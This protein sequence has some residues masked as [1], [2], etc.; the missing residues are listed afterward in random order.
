[1][2]KISIKELEVLFEKIV[3]KLTLEL[4]EN[5]VLETKTS[6]YRSIPSDKWNKF[7]SPED[8]SSAKEIEQG[9][10]N[11]DVME[12]KKLIYENGRFCTY[13]DFDR[14]ASLL[15]ELSQVYNAI[16]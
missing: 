6:A 15:K 16:S 12:L 2:Q 4:G 13:V 7:E 3:E 1:M 10:L 11:D 14:T 9:D 5:G 8:W